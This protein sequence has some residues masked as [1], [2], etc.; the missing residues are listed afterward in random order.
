MAAFVVQAGG[1]KHLGPGQTG[2]WVWNNAAPA[3]AVWSANAV[4]NLSGAETQDSSLEVTRLWRRLLVT[5]HKDSPQSESA[6]EKVEHEIHYEVKNLMN[7]GV[8]F[9]VYL[10]VVS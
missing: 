2:T 8:D 4:P 5:S 3:N 10:S 9:L 1:Q 7:Q 6:T